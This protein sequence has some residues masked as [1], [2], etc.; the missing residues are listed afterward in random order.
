M[1]GSRANDC[2][3]AGEQTA[4]AGRPSSRRARGMG[5]QP[6]G[7]G[8]VLLRRAAWRGARTETTA[9]WKMGDG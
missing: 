4:A 8:R 5:E 3:G 6:A 7:A 1:Q 9:G 2:G